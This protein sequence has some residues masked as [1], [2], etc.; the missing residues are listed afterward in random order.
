MVLIHDNNKQQH[1]TV[2]SAPV[3]QARN[4]SVDQGEK[5]PPPKIGHLKF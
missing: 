3:I 2:I 1:F 5:S 4:Q